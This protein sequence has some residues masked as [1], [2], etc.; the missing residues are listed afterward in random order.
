MGTRPEAIKL[1]PVVLA[2]QD[3]AALVP[4][5][6][7]TGQHRE[8]LHQVVDCF[9][10]QLHRDLG[11]MRPDQS[12]AGL[13]ARLLEAINTVLAETEPAL[14]VV[15]GDTTTALAGALAAFYSRVPVA[16]V[17]AGLRTFR[18]DSPFPEEANRVLVARLAAL[19]FA[20][21]ELAATRLRAEGAAPDRVLVTGNTVIDA[22]RIEAARQAGAPASEWHKCGPLVLVTAHRRESFGDGLAQICA[23]V[24]E[25]AARFPDHR[26]VLP[27][28][29]NPRVRGPVE[30]ALAV[31][32]NVTL[33][34]PVP[35]PVLVDLL[36]ACH[37][38]LT[39]S[40]GI[41]EEAPAFGKPVLVMRDTTERTEGIDAGVVR[42]VGTGQARI[43]AEATRLLTDPAAH[44]AMATAVNPYGD[45]HAAP[46][47]VRRI[48][49]FLA[50]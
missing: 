25:L 44:A 43:V 22:L 6:V 8:M 9:G 4:L 12:L 27:V 16:H 17:E 45:G 3:S 19:H 31:I 47:V 23:A 39:D 18:L 1:A 10:L 48:E 46:R 11:V 13:T 40:G 21:T 50:G 5:A 14:V 37:L 24:A 7:S 15:Q 38:V 49:R 20:P 42:L 28:H 35:Y 26:F 32:P 36:G 33:L 34:E 41:Q 2:L 29:L 30:A